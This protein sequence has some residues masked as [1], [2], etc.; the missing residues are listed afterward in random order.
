MAKVWGKTSL[1]SA[2]DCSQKNKNGGGSLHSRRIPGICFEEDR[3]TSLKMKSMAL[4]S[5]FNGQR[6]VYLERKTVDTRRFLQVPIKAQLNQIPTGL[7][8]K[9][10]KWWDTALQPNMKEVTSSQDLVDSVQC[11]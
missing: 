7:I 9:T 3:F 11:Q 4:R 8:G 6:V 5:D 1:L 2:C 10:P